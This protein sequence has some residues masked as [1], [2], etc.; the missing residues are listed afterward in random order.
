MSFD[1]ILSFSWNLSNPAS[2]SFKDLRFSFQSLSPPDLFIVITF[3]FMCIDIVIIS[4][5]YIFMHVTILRMS[6]LCKCTFSIIKICCNNIAKVPSFRI[7]M[8]ALNDV[9]ERRR[10]RPQVGN[11]KRNKKDEWSIEIGSREK[12]L[13]R[14]TF[15]ERIIELMEISWEEI[16]ID[17]RS[18]SE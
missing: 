8:Y 13:I 10:W 18:I 4:I 17:F 3:W 2:S 16:A 12:L 11:W 6:K 15:G 7:Q 14:H 5:C 1:G 9:N